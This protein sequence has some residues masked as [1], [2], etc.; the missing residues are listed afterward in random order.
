MKKLF[1]L[2]IYL[3]L[4]SVHPTWAE[5]L[6]EASNWCAEVRQSLVDQTG[7][8]LECTTVE[9]EKKKY[10]C[11]I[12]NNYWC[13]KHTSMSNPW[14]GTPRHNG[15]D[16]FQDIDGHAIFKAVDWSV[17]A[18]AIDLKSKYT[19]GKV[20]ANAIAAMH[21]PWCDTLGSKAVVE[22]HG[23]T[24]NDGRARPPSG[25]SG[26][27]CKELSSA[28]PNKGDC[29]AGCNCPPEIAEKLIEGLDQGIGVNDDLKLF[30]SNG[31]PL[32]NLVVVLKNLAFQEQGIR[33]SD[34]AIEK[35]IKLIQK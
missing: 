1:C 12:M 17:R 33:I 22:G 19:R 4:A 21:S 31:D 11:V 30:D 35:G 23:R 13:Q 7:K 6:A 24:C 5:P 32:P 2:L 28:K 20:S 10:R 26:P 34:A 14:R 16:G 3:L 29:Q 9:A 27:L 8:P 15:S 25:F 18:M